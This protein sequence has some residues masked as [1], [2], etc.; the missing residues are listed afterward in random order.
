LKADRDP[1][2]QP[3]TRRIFTTMH[4]GPIEFHLPNRSETDP[5]HLARSRY[6]LNCV[7]QVYEMIDPAS[8]ASYIELPGSN[9]HC[10]S[11]DVSQPNPAQLPAVRAVPIINYSD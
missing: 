1:G 8:S 4:V 9:A 6:S 7:R 5:I 10:Y 11:C 3:G 2:G